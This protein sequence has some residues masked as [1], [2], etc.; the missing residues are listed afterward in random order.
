MIGLVAIV[1]GILLGFVAGGSIRRLAQLRFRFE[2]VLLFV[3]VVQ[4][5]A[6]GRLGVA[7]A[8]T[9][10]LPIWAIASVV[11]SL[12][13]G[14]S[15]KVAG[16]IVAA[17]GLLLNLDVVLINR[18]M[19]VVVS[20]VPRAVAAISRSGGFYH[21]ANAITLAPWAS[22]ALPVRV[23]GQIQVLSIGDV[24]LVIGITTIIA[25]SM[26]GTQVA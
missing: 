11:L 13:L 23:L 12:L 22:D 5:L 8:T 16:A 24:L 25:S 14:L 19:P 6:R 15:H 10:A 17:A 18:G 1:L 21:L 2:P 3:F 9:W 7:G 26:L 20:A 4:A